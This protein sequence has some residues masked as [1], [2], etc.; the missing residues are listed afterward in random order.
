[1]HLSS[2]NRNIAFIISPCNRT[3]EQL[4][5]YPFVI[6]YYAGHGVPN[7]ATKSAFLLPI[8]A[9]GTLTDVCLSVEK[10]YNELAST[11]ANNIVIFLDACFSGAQR[12]EGMLSSAR[13]VAIKAKESTPQGNMVVF[14]AT[15]G[16]QTAFPYS[17][18]GHGM[19][20]YYLLKKLRETQGDVTLGE[21]S[22]YI[23]TNVREQSIVI[24]GKPQT[25]TV[26][27]SSVISET[28]KGWKL[29]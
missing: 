15:T 3:F 20:T 21:L 7:D 16:E 26:S 8:D 6:F 23:T 22:E 17:N 12:G 11:N 14:S 13:G 5:I 4:I 27:P 25:P 29:K 24:N 9:D 10:L 1:M 28:W 2:K 18:Y 19:F